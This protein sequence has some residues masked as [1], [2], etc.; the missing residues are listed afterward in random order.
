MV[1]LYFINGIIVLYFMCFHNLTEL[2]Q[3]FNFLTK[4]DYVQRGF[5][6]ES[7]LGNNSGCMA[8]AQDISRFV[9]IDDLTHFLIPKCVVKSQ[10]KIMS[11]NSR[12]GINVADN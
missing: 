6:D 8:T 3:H 5:L 10:R 9:A 2:S 1:I 7:G 11:C 4:S 12:R